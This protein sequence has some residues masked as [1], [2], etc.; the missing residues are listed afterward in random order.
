MPY[1]T[2]PVREASGY[3][4]IQQ[5]MMPNGHMNINFYHSGKI[6]LI[7][8]ACL[9][10]RAAE[11]GLSTQR[12]QSEIGRVIGRSAETDYSSSGI[13]QRGVRSK[14]AV[15]FGLSTRPTTQATCT[16]AI[17]E[18]LWDVHQTS[19]CSIVRDKPSAALAVQRLELH[20][21]Y[22]LISYWFL[23]AGHTILNRSVRLCT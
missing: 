17:S 3:S 15:T 20:H 11:L 23:K 18:I 1:C 5:I 21:Q 19:L 22:L 2:L 12:N 14:P 6:L 8:P 7:E 4:P 16:R 13:I 10:S 9:Q